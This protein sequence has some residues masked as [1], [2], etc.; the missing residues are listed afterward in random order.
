VCRGDD[1]ARRSRGEQK[2][3]GPPAMEFGVGACGQRAVSLPFSG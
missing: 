2:D 1:P 3:E